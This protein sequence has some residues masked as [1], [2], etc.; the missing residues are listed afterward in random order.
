MNTLLTGSIYLVTDKEVLRTMATSFSHRIVAMVENYDGIED[1]PNIAL[2]SVLLP[3]YS[4]ICAEMDGNIQAFYQEYFIH[5]GSKE[6]DATICLLM[7]AAV[8]GIN[9]ALY[10]P[11]EEATNLHFA[12]AFVQYLHDTYG[13]TV[14]TEQNPF[15]Y[16]QAFDPVI[17][18]RL[19][20]H[21]FI[22]YQEFF[23]AFPANCLIPEMVIPKLASEMQVC[24]FD[25]MQDYVNYFTC[26]K[27]RIAEND[28]KFLTIPV[29]RGVKDA[30]IRQ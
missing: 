6:A 14:G 4:A 12:T 11:K 13:I 22:S 25:N 2:A 9:I 16:D 27:N 30:H 20:L 18:S 5:L 26:Y 17:Y 28:N 29:I 24:M 21:D 19:Y 1:I 3:P 15:A 23:V 8:R 7:A 10:V